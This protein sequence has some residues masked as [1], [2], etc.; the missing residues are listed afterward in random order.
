MSIAFITFCIVCVVLF[1]IF[2]GVINANDM[3]DSE[4]KEIKSRLECPKCNSEDIDL[5][6][7]NDSSEEIHFSYVNPN[8]E[9][10]EFA[11]ICTCNSCNHEDDRCFFDYVEYNKFKL[12]IHR[13]VQRKSL[14]EHSEIIY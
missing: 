9:V 4:Y 14:K 1:I 5:Y 6:F 7:I 2:V 12:A 8:Q 13:M 3:I 11:H 10:S